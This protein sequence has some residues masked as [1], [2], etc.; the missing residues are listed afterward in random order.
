MNLPVWFCDPVCGCLPPRPPF[1]PHQQH[2]RGREAIHFFVFFWYFVK[3]DLFNVRYIK[4]NFT[5]YERNT[6]MINWS[7]CTIYQLQEKNVRKE[8]KKKNIW[9]FVA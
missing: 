3:S 1:R 8:R 4:V 6:A 2:L 9:K 7:P 5:K